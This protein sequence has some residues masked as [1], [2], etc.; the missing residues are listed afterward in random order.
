MPAF[1]NS[2]DKVMDSTALATFLAVA[3]HGSVTAA[4][5]ELHTVQSNVTA[6]MKQM[7]SDLGATLFVRHR[8]WRNP[9]A[10][11]KAPIGLRGTP[12]CAR[13]RGA[14]SSS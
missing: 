8:S 3:K 13:G 7:E 12:E 4:A 5:L 9:H 1:W 6:R 2:D 10:G 14:G 11:R